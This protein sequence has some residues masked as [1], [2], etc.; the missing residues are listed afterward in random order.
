MSQ[1][2]HISKLYLFAKDTDATDIIRG[3]K[4]QE[5]KTLEIWLYNKVNGIDENIYCDYEEDIFQ[6]DL[7]DFKTTFKQIKLYSSRNFSFSSPELIKAINHF[8]M[9]FVKGDYLFD[10][11]LFIF[12][13][14]TSFASQRG[15]KHE[16]LL[17]EW[18]E[19]QENLSEE[20]LD[21]CIQKVRAII[22][23]NI[24][25]QSENIPTKKNSAEF[26][27]AIQILKELPVETWKK[28]AKSIR[29]IF[30]GVT[31]DEAIAQ[32]IKYSMELINQLPFPIVS[33]EHLL[34]L[35]R[36]R[37]I[38]SDKSMALDPKERMI[39]TDLLNHALLNLGSK[40]DKNYLKT[41]EIW[42]EVSDL[43]YFKIGEFY[44]VLFS[45][46][47]CRRNNYLE[48]HSSLWLNLLDKFIAITIPL[49]KYRR[50]AIYEFIWQIL[51]PSVD[52]LPD[53]SLEGFEG[54][55][56]DYFSD[57]ESYDDVNSI[58]DTHNLLTVVATS[59][60]LGLINIEE[61][62]ILRWFVR[63]DKL[64][65]K[66]KELAADK[67]IY[68][69][70]LE[71]E[72]FS[73]FNKSTLGIG[74]DNNVKALK[75]FEEIII[76]LPEAQSYAVSHF[77]KRLDAVIDL[78]IKVGY[79]KDTESLEAF[80]EKL[81]PFIKEREGNFSLARRYIDRG[82]KYINSRNPKSLL[83]AINKFHSAKELYYDEATYEGFVLALLAISQLYASVGMNLASKYYSLSAIWFCSENRDPKLYKRI[84]DSY[85][86]L[87]HADFKQ[88]SWISALSDFEDYIGIRTEL[89][90]AEFNPYIDEIL[91][92][93]IIEASFLLGLMPFISNQLSGFVDYEKTKMGELYTDFLKD[94]VEY[95]ASLVPKMGLQEL[96]S[97]KL[98]SS[99]IDDIGEIRVI[100]WKTFGCIW[101]VEFAN[102]FVTNSI[103]EEFIA[104]IQ[105]IQ[106]D[107]SLNEIDFHL[108]KGIIRLKIEIVT[109]LKSPE[110]LPSKDEYLWKV[111]LPLLESKEASDKNMHYG[112]ITASFKIIL[113]EISL[114][115]DEVFQ[116]RFESL[117][118]KGLGNKAFIIN[119]YQREYRK[120]FSEEKFLASMRNKFKS[121]F[122]RID[123]YESA[124]L[125]CINHE[126]EFYNYEKSIDNIRSR[127]KNCLKAIHLTLKRLKLSEE[128]NEKVIKFQKDGWL[129]W[130]ILLALFNTIIDLKAKNIL[131]Q[132]GRKYTSDLEWIEYLQKT[133]AEIMHV[134]EKET[135]VEIPV[136]VIYGE[137]FDRQMDLVPIHVL[138]SFKLESKSRF[139]DPIALRKFLDEKFRFNTDDIVELSPFVV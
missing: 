112:A 120:V 113:N 53:S 61:K 90:P 91:K 1:T 31:T 22:E 109:L 80:T 45:A 124:S 108:T 62:E 8:F 12:E 28:F 42:K 35:D 73:F 104:L 94:S 131:R 54:L 21:R 11:P 99:P 13:T 9:L 50:Q 93:S 29:W 10:E 32:S 17:E 52:K 132:N 116:V 68:C 34:V 74:E 20:L 101:N 138:K 51:R 65:V 48:D 46:K 19:N 63:F 81:I 87:F 89:D 96:L 123:Y 59:Q 95:T 47:Y 38:I 127:Y 6:R 115:E 56:L 98:N 134:D 117:F 125:S 136:D 67:N 58:E 15:D 41:Y 122:A 137:N 30:K 128:F 26:V 71:I 70:L 85:G 66:S 25:S 7:S 111:F 39:T 44:Q 69:S 119:S 14:N 23:Q 18:V 49:T 75:R 78:L 3:F 103:A 133:I 5:L 64:M 36:L 107:I 27:Q 60:R 33:D 106:S 84:S 126:S 77:G 40:E 88:G 57:F 24:K 43:K 16:T 105:I 2:G 82:M 72:G 135:Y 37:G 130:Q 92:K 100:S 110:Q 76:E 102:D 4:Y 121:E 55:V 79:D 114:L 83:K 97:R 139:P 118:K 129:D 86:I